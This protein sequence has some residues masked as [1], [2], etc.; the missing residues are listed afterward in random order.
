MFI[1]DLLRVPVLTKR[2]R[3]SRYGRALEPGRDRVKGLHAMSFYLEYGSTLTSGGT[4]GEPMNPP[5]NS[6]SPWWGKAGT[7]TRCLRSNLPDFPGTAKLAPGLAET[8]SLVS[9]KWFG[10]SRSAAWRLS[11]GIREDLCSQPHGLLRPLEL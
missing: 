7:G 6:H 11:P 5:R 10:E 8:I 4:S 1:C 9:A 2:P 3:R